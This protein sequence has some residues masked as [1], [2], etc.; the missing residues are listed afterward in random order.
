M[1]PKV[2]YSDG[3]STVLEILSERKQPVTSNE[4]AEIYY[5]RRK[6]EMPYHGRV[7]V[8]AAAHSLKRKAKLNRERF[9][10]VISPRRGPHPKEIH[11]SR[12]T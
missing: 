11:L 4:L 9:D 10:I 6:L 3:E 5:R 12:K 7:A 8:L 1:S 2:K